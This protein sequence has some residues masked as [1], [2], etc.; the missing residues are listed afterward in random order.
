MVAMITVLCVKF[1]IVVIFSPLSSM[2]IY[3][4]YCLLLL[5]VYSMDGFRVVK[6]EDVLPQLDILITATG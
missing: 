1:N 6:L 4:V 2:D 5:F 3:V